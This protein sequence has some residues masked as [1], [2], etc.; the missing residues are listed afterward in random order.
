MISSGSNIF[1][2]GSGILRAIPRAESGLPNKQRGLELWALLLVT[3]AAP[4]RQDP[5]IAFTVQTLNVQA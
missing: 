4:A 1:H 2:L 3:S 5:S